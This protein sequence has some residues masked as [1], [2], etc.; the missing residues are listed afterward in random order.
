MGTVSQL[1]HPIVGGILFLG[2]VILGRQGEVR[3]V[4]GDLYC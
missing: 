1:L 3:L 2:I 4:V